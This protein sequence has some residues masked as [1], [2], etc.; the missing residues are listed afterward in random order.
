MTEQEAE[1]RRNDQ[2][3][4]FNISTQNE[5]GQYLLRPLIDQQLAERPLEQQL[6]PPVDQGELQKGKNILPLKARG[7]ANNAARLRLMVTSLVTG[8]IA[9]LG[10]ILPMLIM[11]LSGGLATTLII[12]SAATIL[13][14]GGLAFFTDMRPEGVMG[15]VAA[16]A[17]V[18][19]VFVGA[20][21]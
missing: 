17:A 4:P 21:T 16:Y 3:D 13:F 11:V 15:A 9:G 20:S 12:S 14:A 18:Y 1:A 2:P 7:A 8:I 5:L 19:V 6:W 10:L